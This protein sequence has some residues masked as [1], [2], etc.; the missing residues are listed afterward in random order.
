MRQVVVS[1]NIDSDEIKMS[2]DKLRR[3]RYNR[4]LFV[5]KFK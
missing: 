1:N 5:G 2:A 4:S 3:L